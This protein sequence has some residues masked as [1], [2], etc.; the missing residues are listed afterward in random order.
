MQDTKSLDTR[1]TKTNKTW[2][3]YSKSF[4]SSGEVHE[5]NKPQYDVSR[6]L[7]RLAQGT[8]KKRER[9]QNHA[10]SLEGLLEEIV[11]LAG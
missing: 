9:V 3:L 4:L 7:Q 1:H 11:L 5:S 10:K 6:A 2:P 8:E